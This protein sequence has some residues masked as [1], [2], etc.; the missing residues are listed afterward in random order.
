MSTQLSRLGGNKKLQGI[1]FG[2]GK[3]TATYFI[4][5]RLFNGRIQWTGFNWKTPNENSRY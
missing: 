2:M 5:A 1:P 3:Q 4:E